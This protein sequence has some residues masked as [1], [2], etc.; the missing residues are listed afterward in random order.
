LMQRLLGPTLGRLQNDFLNPLIQR[1][2]NILMRANRL[3]EIPEVVLEAGGQMRIEYTGPLPR[4]QKMDTVRNS[5]EWVIVMAQSAEMFPELRDLLDPDGF[6]RETARLMS[7]PAKMLR[8]EEEVM[9]LR[10]ERQEREQ[11]ENEA[12]QAHMEGEAAQAQGKGMQELNNAFI[13]G[14]AA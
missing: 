11:A 4:A 9:A 1:T 14:T 7:V 6:G 5:Q 10:Q 3:P 8:S 12:A 13:P 2:F